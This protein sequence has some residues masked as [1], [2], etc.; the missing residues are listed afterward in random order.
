MDTMQT[1][2][3]PIGRSPAFC[4]KPLYAAGTR[5]QT[6]LLHAMPL[7]RAPDQ[8]LSCCAMAVAQEPT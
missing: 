8:G 7:W 1:P 6:D 4:T 3:G 2:V 5:A